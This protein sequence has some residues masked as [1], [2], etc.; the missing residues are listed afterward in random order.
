MTKNSGDNGDMVIVE[1]EI[2]LLL[3]IIVQV[4]K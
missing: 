4:I 3:E 2:M 1:E